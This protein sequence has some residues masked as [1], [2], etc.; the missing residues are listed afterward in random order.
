M[1]RGSLQRS[2]VRRS[3]A[4]GRLFLP[5]LLG[6]MRGWL[7]LSKKIFLRGAESSMCFGGTS[8]TSMMHSSCSTSFS[9]GNSG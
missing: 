4:P 5:R 3:F 2:T 8:S 1:K 9:P 6:T 7:E